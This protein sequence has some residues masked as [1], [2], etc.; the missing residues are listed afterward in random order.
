MPWSSGGLTEQA[1]GTK[2]NLAMRQSGG[3]H[4]LACH[5]LYFLLGDVT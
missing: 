3:E 1:A 4:A 5:D 2:W